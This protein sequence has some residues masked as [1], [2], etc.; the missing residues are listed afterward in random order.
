MLYRGPLAANGSPRE[1]HSIRQAFHPQL[2][3]LFKQSPL[4]HH[5]AN[6]LNPTPP[7]GEV[8]LILPAVGA[9]QF[10]ALVSSRLRLFRYLDILFLRREEPVVCPIVSPA[11]T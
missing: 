5:S 11:V 8:S 4:S 2:A 7:P 6:F 10:A 3:E 1:K 9:Y